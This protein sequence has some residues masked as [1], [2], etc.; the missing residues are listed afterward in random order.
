VGNACTTRGFIN[1]ILRRT[2]Q[3]R[4]TRCHKWEVG[5]RGGGFSLGGIDKN[6]FKTRRAIRCL[7]TLDPPQPCF[8]PSRCCIV[9]HLT[10]LPPP[11]PLSISACY[12]SGHS[13]AWSRVQRPKSD[14]GEWD[15]LGAA[16]WS[17]LIR[18]LL[19]QPA[20][21][22]CAQAQPGQ[23]SSIKGLILVLHAPRLQS[24]QC[25]DGHAG[26]DGPLPLGRGA[27]HSAPRA[28]TYTIPSVNSDW[29]TSTGR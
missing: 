23:R 13:R 27:L 17:V 10:S 12:C 11:P 7:P 21:C 14:T 16:R 22:P 4:Q 28:S 26:A 29:A 6:E 5:D 25:S 18:D 9:G 2:F 3:S 19:L 15:G 1:Q 24:Q 20:C 8:L